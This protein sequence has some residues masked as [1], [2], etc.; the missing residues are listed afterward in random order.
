MPPPIGSN[1]ARVLPIHLQPNQTRERLD[2]VVRYHY[3]ARQV[4]AE[5]SGSALLG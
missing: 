2:L 4:V 3:A 5:R 1:G